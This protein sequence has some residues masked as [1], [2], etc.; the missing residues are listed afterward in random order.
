MIEKFESFSIEYPNFTEHGDPLCSQ[1]NPDMFFPD[2]PI[3]GNIL[4]RN[5]YTFE[6]EAK[7]IC[8]SCPY[9]SD[10]LDYALKNQDLQG[11]WGGSTEKQRNKLRRG[12]FVNLGIPA[13][14]HV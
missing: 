9:N 12:Q 3:E 14:R 4:N 7:L 5:V 11:I 10:C 13:R 8:S 2:E 6:R 1:T